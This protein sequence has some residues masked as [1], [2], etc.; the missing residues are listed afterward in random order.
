MVVRPTALSAMPA[1]AIV[2][3]SIQTAAEAA[4]IAQSPARR[5]TFSC[6]LPRAGPERDPHLGQH[7]GG[8]DGRHVRA[9]VELVHAD[10][11][12]A[13]RAADHGRRPWR[14]CRR[15]TGPRP[16]R[17]GR[18][19]RRSCRGCA[20]PGRRS[21]ARR[22]GRAGSARASRSD[23]SR[24]TCRVSAPI[25][26][27]PSCSRMYESSARSLMSIRCSGLARRSFIIGSRLWPA[28]DDA[29]LGPEPL[30]GR[31]RPSTLVARSYSN[32]AGVC[33]VLLSRR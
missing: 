22:R 25:R 4:A 1:S 3:P 13:A 31:D 27:S 17:P 5:S 28:G 6:A 29:R 18:A 24:S 30:Q 14:R 16:R 20:R 9:D 32:A 2:P 11:A 21:P 10:D 7:L 26:I 15:P 12:L 23:F 19:S 8:A 33:N